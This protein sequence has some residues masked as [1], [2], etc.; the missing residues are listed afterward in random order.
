MFDLLEIITQQKPHRQSLAIS[1][2]GPPVHLPHRPLD[3]LVEA[4]TRPTDDLASRDRTSRIQINQNIYGRLDVIQSGLGCIFG[5]DT[6]I[7]NR[8][9]KVFSFG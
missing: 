7:G 1:L 8:S 5:F 6:A 3:R 9:T 2:G 4:E